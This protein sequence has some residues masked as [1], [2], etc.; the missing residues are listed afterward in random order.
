MENLFLK[1]F[2][3]KLNLFYYNGKML[4]GK[5]MGGERGERK[6][7]ERGEKRGRIKEERKREGRGRT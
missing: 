7:G 5:F 2:L 3:M 6:R 1:G 4:T